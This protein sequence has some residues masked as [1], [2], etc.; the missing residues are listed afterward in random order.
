M[1]PTSTRIISQNVHL[2]CLIKRLLTKRYNSSLMAF[3]QQRYNHDTGD[4]VSPSEHE[5]AHVKLD[6]S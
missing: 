1:I 4:H 5:K 6:N 2:K 3:N